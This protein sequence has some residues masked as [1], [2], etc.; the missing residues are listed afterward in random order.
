[1]RGKSNLKKC[2]ALALFVI[3]IFML[4][5]WGFMVSRCWFEARETV[6]ISPESVVRAFQDA[7]YRVSNV[8]ETDDHPGPMAIP[9][10]GIRF[11]IFAN[12]TVFDVL[13]VSYDEQERARRSAIAVNDLDRRMDGGYSY[14]FWRGTVLVQIFPSDKDMG[15]ELDAVL[16]AIE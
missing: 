3:V 12:G 11:D 15:R 16:K 10:Y 8:Q 4:S 9:E 6:D 5:V 13:V 2:L 1:M 7:G 14:A